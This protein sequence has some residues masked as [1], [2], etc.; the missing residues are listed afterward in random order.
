MMVD[1][2]P[3]VPGAK[4]TMILRHGC[5]QA[6]V[7]HDAEAG[8]FHKE[9]LGFRDVITFQGRSADKLKQ[10]FADSVDDY[11]DFCRTRREPPEVPHR[12]TKTGLGP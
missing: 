6:S 1:E 3:L 2:G 9:V 5:Y 7:A 10:A 12:N 8:I 11:F 4:R